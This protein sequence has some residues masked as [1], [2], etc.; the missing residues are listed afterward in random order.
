MSIRW[1][2]FEPGRYEDMVSVLLSRLYPNAQ[3]IDGKGGDGG[4]DV[5]IVHPQDGSIIDAFEL[6]SHTGRMG[7]KQ[8]PQVARSLERAALLKPPRWTLVVPIDPTPGEFTWFQK[9][10][11]G[12]A[13]PTRWFGKTWLDEKMSAFPDIRRYF[14]EGAKDEVHRLLREI[15]EEQARVTD[16]PDA[17]A[18]F[19]TL[20]ER[21]NE[22]DPHYRYETSTGPTAANSLPTDVVF[23]VGF[24]DVR[25][26][27]Y[28]KY[29]GALKDR[30]VT[31]NVTLFV[32]P[33]HEVLQNALDYGLEVNIQP[34]LVRSVTIDAP[35]G[36]GCSLTEAEIH[37]MPTDNRLDE[38]VTLALDVMEG[39]RL[40]ASC[41]IHLTEQTSGLRGSVF[42]GTDS[43]GWLETRLTVNV[44]ARDAAVE[45]RLA[46]RP[47]LPSAL[48]PLCRWLGEWQPSHDL[49]IRWPGSFEMR[50]EIRTTFFEDGSLCRVVEALAYLQD[51]NVIYWEMPTSLTPEQARDIVTAAT[52]L[53]G[54]S[55]NFT[56]KAFN[57]NLDAR[58]PELKE[59][60]DGRPRSFIRD[61]D[62]WLK[63]EEATIRLGRIRTY[64]ESARL[65]NPETVKRAV[66][67]GSV[68]HLQL[69]PGDSNK[70]QRTLVPDPS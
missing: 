68:P 32:G 6:K 7:T 5:Q 44:E 25:V 29:L 21:L 51:R 39:D 34:E 9:L 30:P 47:I 35:S 43:T 15:R 22:I 57:L 2:D 42:T 67:S 38:P 18:R 20:R 11:T 19:R 70:G 24:S 53:R 69:I 56:W 36:L 28:P 1:D 45:F 48:L 14:L 10:G 50:G 33:D 27:V 3:R 49:K 4:R 52:L 58:G 41:P 66:E 13:F 37:L 62:S 16:V 61:Q 31:I 60:M 46:P 54:E 63:L 64:Y 55:I 8:R 59:L 26:D 12:Y 17:V 40:L 23:S 65:V